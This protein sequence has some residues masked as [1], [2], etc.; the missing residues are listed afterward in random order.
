MT[1]TTHHSLCMYVD[2]LT[3]RVDRV[4][5]GASAS[6][7]WTTSASVPSLPYRRPRLLARRPRR[8]VTETLLR[9]HLLYPLG[10][11]GGGEQQTLPPR[12]RR[13]PSCRTRSTSPSPS[14]LHAMDA[15]R[16]PRT[17]CSTSSR[18]SMSRGGS[19]VESC[20]GLESKATG[21]RLS[22]V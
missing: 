7:P 5:F 10:G 22:A 12:C 21:Y 17:P 11:R 13:C 6:A 2:A 16:R 1:I 15:L 8:L 18:W 3:A 9:R 20:S 19:S 4:Y 14:S